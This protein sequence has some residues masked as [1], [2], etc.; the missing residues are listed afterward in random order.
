MDTNT[1]ENIVEA[2]VK[3]FYQ[4]SPRT[5]DLLITA[6]MVGG[7]VYLANRFSSDPII[8]V[9]LNPVTV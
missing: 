9:T 2:P 3:K 1:A 4:L 8:D 6:V 7:A 5:R